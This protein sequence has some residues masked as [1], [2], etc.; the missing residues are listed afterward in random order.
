MKILDLY[1]ARVILAGAAGAL[2]VLTGLDMFIALMREL[3][4]VDKGDYGYPEA[5]LYVLLTLPARMYEL[6][7]AA[8]LVG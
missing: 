1:I 8:V 3:E 7:P 6:F 4:F 2:L 5:V